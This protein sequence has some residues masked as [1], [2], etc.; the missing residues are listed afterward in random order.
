[1][2]GI[3]SNKVDSAVKELNEQFFKEY[4]TTAIGEK[5]GVRRKPAP[6]T[7]NEAMKELGVTPEEV[8][9]VGDSDVDIATAG[10]AGVPVISVL[11]G[12][13]ERD[14]LEKCGATTFVEQP[15]ELLDLF[16]LILT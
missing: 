16:L 6:D 4:T 2:L 8:I 11:W 14:F 12:F 1:M 9:Y 13:R 3:V 5:Q 7:V 10:N 15:L